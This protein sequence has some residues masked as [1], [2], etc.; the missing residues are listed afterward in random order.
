MNRRRQPASRPV[1]SRCRPAAIDVHQGG[2]GG[3][4]GR[5]DPW[6][7]SES[8]T[9]GGYCSLPPPLVLALALVS[10]TVLA[11]ALVLVPVL[12]LMP[13]LLV[14]LIVYRCGGGAELV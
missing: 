14:L 8:G 3:G 6:L 10:A 13:V 1:P 5:G 2:G 4:G 7:C 9:G 11:L 12:V